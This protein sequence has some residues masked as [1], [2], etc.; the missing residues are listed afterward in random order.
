MKG[1]R[2]AFRGCR[3]QQ[4]RL[5]LCNTKAHLKREKKKIRRCKAPFML[6]CFVSFCFVLCV[7]DFHL[8]PFLL[9]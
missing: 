9:K 2:D 3:P 8:F 6:F 1:G 7:G 4:G 5:C